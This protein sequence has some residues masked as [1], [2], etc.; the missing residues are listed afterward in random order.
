MVQHR[1]DRQILVAT[2][3]TEG[4]A[5]TIAVGDYVDVLED[6]TYVI[7]PFSVERNLVRPSFTRIPD[8]FASTGITTNDVV[9][10]E[11]EFTFTVELTS[12]NGGP[13][14]GAPGW[15][16]L[17]LACG[18]E[19]FASVKYEAISGGTVSGGPFLHREQCTA[20]TNCQTVST[21]FNGDTRFY[22]TGT[23]P[24]DTAIDG[25]ISS[26]TAT[27]T[28]AANAA[29]IAY[30][31]SIAAAD[32][33]G[34]SATIE[35]NLD[36]R[37]V[38]AR[39][40]RGTCSIQFDAMN[41]V[42][43]T[44]TMTGIMSSMTDT[45]NN[46]SSVVY[47]H[48]LPPTFVAAGLS[49]ME[50]TGT[51]NHTGAIFQALTINFGNTVTMREDANSASGWKAARITDRQPTVSFN[52]DA[53]S[54]GAT[55]A[56]VYDYIEAWAEGTPAR[57][58]FE[59]GDGLDD[60]SFHFKMPALQWTGISDGDRDSYNIYEA[61]CKLTGGLNGDS[62]IHDGTGDTQRYSDRGADNELVIICT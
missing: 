41:R 38:T 58:Q 57:M 17:M 40:C 25:D 37:K 6:V 15:E 32:G 1:F 35:L 54:G 44:F 26:A 2:E 43:M 27:V 24:G 45:G 4:V 3:A 23:D 56:S 33:D 34:S 60:N 53:I 19:K 28:N 59:V 31:F 50:A 18:M 20:V 8:F 39:G 47:G 29:G 36:G 13:T 11:I 12:L 10:A 14:T 22:Y 30:G 16:P 61:S 46:R 42:L 49:L 55:S 21:I 52:P 5:E 9:V 7:R 62:V 51:T 48:Q